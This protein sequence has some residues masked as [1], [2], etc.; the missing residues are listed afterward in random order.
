MKKSDAN[1]MRRLAAARAAPRCTAT[2]KRTGLPC[3]APAVRG[4]AVCRMHGAGGGAPNG[5]RNG[6]YVHGA[7]TAESVEARKTVIALIRLS[8]ETMGKV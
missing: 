2:S 7:R 6:A 8:R 1:L 5:I 3:Q 4:W